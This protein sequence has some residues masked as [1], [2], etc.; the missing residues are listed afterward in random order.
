LATPAET[1]TERRSAAFTRKLLRGADLPPQLPEI[2]LVSG[3]H[4]RAL[5]RFLEDQL[6]SYQHLLESDPLGSA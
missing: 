3:Q 6:Q 2:R 1:W 4:D 5:L